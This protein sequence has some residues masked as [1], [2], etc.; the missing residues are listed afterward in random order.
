MTVIA[1][2][3]YRPFSHTQQVKMKIA[4]I[5]Q[6]P[7]IDITEVVKKIIKI[8]AFVLLISLMFFLEAAIALPVLALH[9][10]SPIVER[11]A[12]KDLRRQREVA[13]PILERG[14]AAVIRNDYP[15][16]LH[17]LR[18]SNER[19]QSII[20]YIECLILAHQLGHTELVLKLEA[21][22]A[23]IQRAI[24]ADQGVVW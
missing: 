4:E 1:N 21:R 15:P 3:N 8:A 9:I 24:E 10:C 5:W 14:R 11:S 13:L 22:I 6:R 19:D 16:H 20:D 2:S 23:H 17:L 7:T 18:V 12:I